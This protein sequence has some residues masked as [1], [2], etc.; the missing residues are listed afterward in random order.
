[1]SGFQIRRH[2]DAKHLIAAGAEGSLK[3]RR[4]RR[5]EGL[6]GASSAL[7]GAIRERIA[8]AVGACC[9]LFGVGL[10]VARNPSNLLFRLNRDHSELFVGANANAQ[11]GRQ[12]ETARARFNVE[13]GRLGRLLTVVDCVS[14]M[15]EEGKHLLDV[16][17]RIVFGRLNAN[18][19]RVAT[20][21]RHSV[22]LPDARD[23]FVA[24][25]QRQVILA[26]C[27]EAAALA[28]V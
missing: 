1:M 22:R 26:I 11:A 27:L 9:C 10:P 2:L 4:R 7:F 24:V 5:I 16:P 17:N 12:T 18:R 8:A 28:T 25:N 20:E 14:R 3:S 15:P 13:A 6:L 23:H 21:S 19:I